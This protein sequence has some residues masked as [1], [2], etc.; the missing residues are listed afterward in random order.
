[1]EFKALK[2]KEVRLIDLPKMME[3]PDTVL[4]L[5]KHI[6]KGQKFAEIFKVI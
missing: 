3:E 5:R 4:F 1:M 2:P 6:K